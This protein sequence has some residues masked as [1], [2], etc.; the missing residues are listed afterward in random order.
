[1][2]VPINACKYEKL[3]IIKKSDV[4]IQNLRGYIDG[5]NFQ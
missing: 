2:Y 1:M 5:I 4:E 3:V